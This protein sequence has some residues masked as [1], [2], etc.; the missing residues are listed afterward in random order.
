M[1]DRTYF[2]LM[3]SLTHTHIH[4]HTHTLSIDFINP[5]FKKIMDY[6]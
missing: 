5:I 3:T 6:T 2:F 1:R 4:T